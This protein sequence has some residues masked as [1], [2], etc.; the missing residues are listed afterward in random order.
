MA[1]LNTG[2]ILTNGFTQP[3]LAWRNGTMGWTLAGQEPSHLQHRQFP[4]L[5]E[6]SRRVALQGAQALALRAVVRSVT[7]SQISEWQQ[8]D[9]RTLYLFDVRTAEEF[10]AGH[11]AGTR[12]VPGGQLIQETD[13]YA[14][15]RG[16]RIVLVDDDGVR[17]RMAASWLAQMNWEV[18]VAEVK[19][20]DLT[21]QGEWKAQVA[22]APAV[23][24]V[25]PEQLLNW[26][27]DPNTGVLDLTTSANFRNRR[28]PGAVW[29][30]RGNIPQVIAAHPEKKR[31]VITCT[32]GLLARYAVT[33]V[34][35][36]TGKPV[37]LLDKGTV[38]WIDQG[39]LLERGDSQYLDNAQDRYRRPY[40]GIDVSAQ[41]M[42]DYLDW[43]FGLVE[44]LERDST[45]GFRTLEA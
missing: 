6:T 34:A 24:S 32:S 14:S 5:R 3:V 39:L 15:V 43:E 25:R 30:T 20:E 41:A 18:Y 17:A 40:E 28:I 21:E 33:E 37:Y 13:H 23:E 38:G 22:P 42:Q 7:L 27:S 31:W 12:H 19:A 10:R 16:A 29:T 36:L 1:D 35:E 44:Q 9:A 4:A 2:T 8:E 11:L 45:H 26:L